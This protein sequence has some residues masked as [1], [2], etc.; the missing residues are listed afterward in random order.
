MEMMTDHQPMREGKAETR[1]QS[2]KPM[3][4]P[5]AAVYITYYHY[6]INFVNSLAIELFSLQPK[7]L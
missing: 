2:V 5:I 4:L 6:L 3:C 7:T 1:T